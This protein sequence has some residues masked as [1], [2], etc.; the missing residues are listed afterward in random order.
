MAGSGEQHLDLASG[1]NC[2]V[3]PTCERT[4]SADPAS[5]AWMGSMGFFLF[6][7]FLVD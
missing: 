3:D 2:G 5:S 4:S 1:H 7:V 6:F